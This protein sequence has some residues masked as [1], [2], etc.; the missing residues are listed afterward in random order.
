[1]KNRLN[2]I[3][4]LPSLDWGGMGRTVSDVSCHLPEGVNQTLVLLE[5]KVVYPYRGR[6][7]VLGKDSL[8]RL[9]VKGLRTLLNVLKF[10]KIVR[11]EK[12]DVVLAFHHHARAINCLAKLSLPTGRYRSIIAALGVASQYQKYFASSRTWLQRVLVFLVHKYS[13]RIIA[14]SEGVKS[15]LV[16]NHKVE[17]RRIEVIYSPVDVKKSDPNGYGNG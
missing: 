1:M 6:L 4:F 9:P 13:H 8:K 11:K 5:D 3:I 15:D 17:P 7:R 14:C 12:P 16:A 2:L 10:R